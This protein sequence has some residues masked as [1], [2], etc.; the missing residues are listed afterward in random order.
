MA[1]ETRRRDECRESRLVLEAAGIPVQ[2]VRSGSGWLLV[3]AEQDLGIATTELEAYRQEN[4]ERA[5]APPPER[6]QLY[7]GAAFGIVV[8]GAIIVSVAVL[9]AY[10]A[11]GVDWMAAGSMRA[12]RVLEGQWWRVTTA[13]TLHVDLQH[14]LGNLAMGGLFCFFASRVLGGGIGWLVIVLA[15]SLGNGINA[16]VQPPEHTSVG[17][18]TAVFAALGVIVAHAFRH[19]EAAANERPLKRWAPLVGGVLLLAFT[20]VGGERTDVVAH[21]TGFLAGLIVGWL[22]CRLRPVWMADGRV[23]QAAGVLAVGLVVGAWLMAL[24]VAG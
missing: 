14:L 4:R 6:V 1:L 10:S 12:G 11:Y 23:Q 21:V 20:G 7:G 15:G 17:A 8:Y 5:E 9:T 16:L 3:V 22:G 19:R 13:L 2:T 18:S 24:A